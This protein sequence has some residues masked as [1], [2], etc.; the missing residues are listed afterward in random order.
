MTKL[1]ES[2][3]MILPLH[4]SCPTCLKITYFNNSVSFQEPPLCLY[5]VGSYLEDSWKLI[6][7]TRCNNYPC[8]KSTTH[9]SWTCFLFFGSDIPMVHINQ[10]F[11]AFA[12]KTKEL[13]KNWDNICQQVL[14]I[15]AVNLIQECLWPTDVE[16]VS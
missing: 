5:F 14:L 7:L 10:W 16:A 12:A 13:K 9:F 15:T 6:L 11:L 1:W 3:H 2:W 8:F 4:I